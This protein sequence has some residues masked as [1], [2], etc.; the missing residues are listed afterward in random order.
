MSSADIDAVVLHIYAVSQV[1]SRDEEGRFLVNVFVALKKGELLDVYDITGIVA[2]VES[3]F[4]DREIGAK[5][6]M[7]LCMAGNDFLPKFQNI[8]HLDMLSLF[9]RTL[10]F[11]SNMI[12]LVDGSID[13]VVHGFH[14]ML[15]LSQI[16]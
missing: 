4:D 14:E 9:L 11:R 15:V 7:I 3:A 16:S 10:T 8:S 13:S 2:K 12:S 1:L 5:I 6:A